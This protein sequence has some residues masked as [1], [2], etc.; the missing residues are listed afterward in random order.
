[1]RVTVHCRGCMKHKKIPAFSY[2]HKASNG[3]PLCNSCYERIEWNKKQ[4]H[5]SLRRNNKVT[6]IIRDDVDKYMRKANVRD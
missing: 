2:G 3:R 5:N 6:S 4:E 1:M